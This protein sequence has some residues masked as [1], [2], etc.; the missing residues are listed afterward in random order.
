MHYIPKFIF[1]IRNLH[2]SDSSSVHHQ[3][4][5][6]VHT[7]IGVGHTILLTVCE[8]DQ[9]GTSWSCS[10]IW[11]I[12]ASSWFY[13]KNLS[14]CT[15]TWTSYIYIYIYNVNVWWGALIFQSYFWN[16]SLHVS[17]SSSVHHQEFFTVHRAV[18]YVKQVCWQLAASSSSSSK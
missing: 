9:D 16:K 18:V 5:F 17:E 13:Y 2:V 8:H 7:A 3:E 12:S 11:E 15:V 10:S 6:T 1:G 4:F 14:R